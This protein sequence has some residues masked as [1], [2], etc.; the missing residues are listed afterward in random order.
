MG[1]LLKDRTVQRDLLRRDPAAAEFFKYVS[2]I[3]EPEHF[4]GTFVA[5]ASSAV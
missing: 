4:I 5:Q 1:H 3:Q 2:A